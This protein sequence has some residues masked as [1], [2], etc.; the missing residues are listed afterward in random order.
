M[1]LEIILTMQVGVDLP[2]LDCF[3]PDYITGDS[4]ITKYCEDKITDE[5]KARRHLEMFL[6]CD[7]KNG[8]AVMS[9]DTNSPERYYIDADGKCKFSYEAG[10]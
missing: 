3:V 6:R 7:G 5:A 1:L 10:M 2:K 9:I 4:S 8:N